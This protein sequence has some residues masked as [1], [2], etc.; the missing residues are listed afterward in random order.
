[1]NH[2][3]FENDLYAPVNAHLEAVNRRMFQQ[4]GVCV[5]YLFGPQSCGKTTLIEETAR[6]MYVD[7]RIG[8]IF[9]EIKTSSPPTRFS[10]HLDQIANAP[11][12]PCKALIAVQVYAAIQNMDLE[13][14]DLLFIEESPRKPLFDGFPKLGQTLNVQVLS[15]SSGP[16]DTTRDDHISL[17]TSAI[18]IN[19]MDLVRDFEDVGS[20]DQSFPN[21]SDGFGC[22]PMSLRNGAGIE[23]WVQWLQSRISNAASNAS[24]WFG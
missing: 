14:V 7:I 16:D 22:F 19:K 23:A 11:L 10:A 21:G 18:V 13:G 20:E 12:R 5:V 3:L 24:N 9:I 15:A 2:A 17:Q 4:A 6:R 1:V 8:A